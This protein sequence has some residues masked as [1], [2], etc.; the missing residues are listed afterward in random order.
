[1]SEHNDGDKTERSQETL[2]QSSHAPHKDRALEHLEFL[3]RELAVAKASAASAL[4][5][6]LLVEANEQLVVA[7]LSA[8]EQPPT[9]NPAELPELY[10]AMR[11]ANENLIISAL[12]A[13]KLQAHAEHALLEQKN[14]LA[15]VA[16]EMRNPLTPI[17]MLAERIPSMPAEKIP[18][19]CA[20]IEGQVRHLARMVEDLLDV[21]RLSTG[22]LR[23][24]R[25]PV[26]ILL[27]LNR[28]VEACA[29]LTSVKHLQVETDIPKTSL[30]V[31]GD[32]IRIAQIFTNVITNAAKY[33][34]CDGCIRLEVSV[35]ADVMHVVISDNG[36]GISAQALPVIFDAYFQDAQAIGF[37]GSGLGIGLTVVR[38]LVEA[39]GGSVRG[40]SEGVG[41]G[42]QFTLTFP[43]LKTEGH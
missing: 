31:D 25:S 32:P 41:K 40:S 1:M 43:L 12:H 14:A 9:P 10:H 22:K 15:S 8:R 30:M 27:I 34:P 4:Q 39:H 37:N 6:Q 28:A 11:E 26:D 7:A 2:G 35:E 20:L 42:S 5:M 17:S 23:L 19:M 38:E 36:I 24:N 16:H 29:T 13:Q 33:T 21:S 18:E 3:Q